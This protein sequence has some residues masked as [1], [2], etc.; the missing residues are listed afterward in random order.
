VVIGQ[1][2]AAVCDRTPWGG[3]FGHINAIHTENV[4]KTKDESDRLRD[5]KERRDARVDKLIVIKAKCNAAS[6]V[7][8]DICEYLTN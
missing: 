6:G 5:E 1:Y 7:T 2:E 3:K 8:K 4:D